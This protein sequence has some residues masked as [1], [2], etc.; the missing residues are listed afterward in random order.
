MITFSIAIVQIFLA[1]VLIA[2]AIIMSNR[3]DQIENE[4]SK[5]KTDILALRNSLSVV[6][7]NLNKLISV[8]TEKKVLDTEVKTYSFIE[9][10]KLKDS[11]SLPELRDDINN[12]L[13]YLDVEYKDVLITRKDHVIKLAPK[14]TK[15]KNKK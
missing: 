14:K 5:N 15:K 9:R 1:V 4:A 10:L 12:I 6:K 3:F 13:E 8:L 2:V 11:I 7:E